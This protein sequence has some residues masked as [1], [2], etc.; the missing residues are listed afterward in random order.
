MLRYQVEF[1][2]VEES[3]GFTN[4]AAVLEGPFSVKA[5]GEYITSQR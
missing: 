4:K 5:V 1:S 2:D 3:I